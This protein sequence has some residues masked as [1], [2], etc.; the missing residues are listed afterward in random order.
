[1]ENVD[2]KI[3]VIGLL[4]CLLFFGQCVKAPGKIIPSFDT[5]QIKDGDL[6]FRMCDSYLSRI[7]RDCSQKDKKYSHTGVVYQEQDALYVIHSEAN[8]M[9]GIGGVRKEKLDQFLSVAT[10]WAVYRI[11]AGPTARRPASEYAMDYYLQ[12]IPFDMEFDL[13][14]T[15]AFYCSE[16]VAK[17]INSALGTNAIQPGMTN[18]GK[19]FIAI[20][21]VYM[22]PYM[23]FVC[24]YPKKTETVESSTHFKKRG[25][26]EMPNE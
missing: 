2:R 20:D 19:P 8:E 23:E 3:K 21:D 9:T 22:N 4:I 12:G 25:L 6:I 11:K 14:D 1:M 15:T 24:A 7:I 5:A 18:K 26:S 10:D 13:T 17:C 16:L